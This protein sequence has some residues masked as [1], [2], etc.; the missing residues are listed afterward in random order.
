M[1]FCPEGAKQTFQ[2]TI[3]LIMNFEA[4]TIRRRSLAGRHL[5]SPAR[6]LQERLHNNIQLGSSM[7]RLPQRLHVAKAILEKPDQQTKITTLTD[8]FSF[9]SPFNRAKHYQAEFGESPSQAAARGKP[10]ILASRRRSS[11]S[12]L[13]GGAE[14]I[15]INE[16][17]HTSK[18][19]TPVRLDAFGGLQVATREVFTPGIAA[20]SM[21]QT[22]P[23]HRPR[24][25]L[26]RTR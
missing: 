5:R 9:A 8:D 6:W 16:R 1:E 17:R 7:G 26:N 3:A 13:Q 15:K 2:R 22:R 4:N 14:Q 19:Q 20:R 10:V 18:R 25:P 21:P 12:A 23:L 11:N 24:W